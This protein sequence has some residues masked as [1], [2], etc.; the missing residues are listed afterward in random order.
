[1]ETCTEDHVKTLRRECGH[2]QAKEISLTKNNPANTLI[3]D[4]GT[5]NCEKEKKKS[6]V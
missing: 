3:S 6:A 4:T 1:M 5:Q 2:P